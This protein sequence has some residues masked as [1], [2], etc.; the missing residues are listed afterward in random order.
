MRIRS[1]AA[2][3]AVGGV[4]LLAPAVPASAHGDTVHL[5][6]TGVDNG[7]VTTAASFE[8]DR[9]PVVEGFAGSLAATS[10]DGRAVG[11]WRL[12]AVPGHPGSYT[13]REVLP[14]GHWKITVDCA[15]PDL[16]HGER[17]LDVAAAAIT[18]PVGSMPT[19]GT[20][21][22]PTVV[23]SPVVTPGTV[24]GPTVPAP[25][26]TGAPTSTGAGNGSGTGTADPTTSGAATPAPPAPGP[27]TAT[28]TSDVP[29][30][31][32]ADDDGS[33]V[34]TWAAIGTAV[35]AVVLVVVGF[36]LRRRNTVR[37]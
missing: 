5:E 18:D 26:P 32:T 13:T 4:A 3:L 28:A 17:E 9:D 19:A 21:V 37:G 8:N 14:S 10:S 12:V 31:A 35:V 34:A 15:F 1:V 24:T 29:A 11:P 23:P 27:A 22:G 20:P 6:V 2:A 16:G 25:A 30:K 7:H 36:R 33:T